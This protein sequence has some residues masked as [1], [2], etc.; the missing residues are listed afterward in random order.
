MKKPA[1]RGECTLTGKERPAHDERV[2]WE[3]IYFL[4]ALGNCENH[5][6]ISSV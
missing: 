6:S 3:E 5:S 4:E 2:N 1:R